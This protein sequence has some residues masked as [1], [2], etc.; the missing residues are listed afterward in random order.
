MTQTA[1]RAGT[2]GRSALVTGASRGIGLGIARHLARRGY[3]LI[4]TS[5]TASDLDLVAEDLRKSSADRVAHHA[6]DWPSG[7]PFPHS[8][9]CTRRASDHWTP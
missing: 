5:R 1:A 4:I 9:T 3:G 7:T 6:L 8:W 2:P